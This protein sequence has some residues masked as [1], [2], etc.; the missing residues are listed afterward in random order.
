MKHK[1]LLATMLGAALFA[2]T[3]PNAHGVDYPATDGDAELT[4]SSGDPGAATEV[5]GCGFGPGASLAISIGS[6]SMATSTADAQ[7]CVF[8]IVTVPDDLSAGSHEITTTGLNPDGG[9]HTLSA[10]FMVNGSI[11]FTGA[12]SRVYT[13]LAT[14]LLAVGALFLVVTRRRRTA[15]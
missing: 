8:E 15:A 9:T 11:A 2:A 12:N 1:L 5:A 7:G 4:P 13:G 10:S 3:A 14:A 6:E